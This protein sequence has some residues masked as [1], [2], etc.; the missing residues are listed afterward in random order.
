MTKITRDLPEPTTIC[1]NGFASDETKNCVL[2]RGRWRRR[3]SLSCMLCT[4]MRA[5]RAKRYS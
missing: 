3:V 4:A 5:L 2:W 1:Q